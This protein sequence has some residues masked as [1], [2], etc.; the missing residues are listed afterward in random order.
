MS[1]AAAVRRRSLPSRLMKSFVRAAFAV[2]ALTLSA[3][4]RAPRPLVAGSDACD[5]CRMG[6]VDVRFGGELQG[7]NGRLYAFDAIE[8][9]ASFYLDAADRD[10][11]RSLWVADYATSKLIAVDSAVF[12]R[13]TG[14]HSPM[15]RS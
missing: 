7:K 4:G 15:G 9:L 10:D 5:Y 6:V 8:C 14:V 1:K 12:V 13:A 11:V 3:C 2:L